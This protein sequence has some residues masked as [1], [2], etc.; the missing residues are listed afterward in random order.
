[1]DARWENLASNGIISK[2]VSALEKRKVETF[3]VEN[4]MQALEKALEIVPKRST[5]YLN[6]SVTLDSIGLSKII[7]ASA[8]YVS[9]RKRI[10]QIQDEKDRLAARKAGMAAAD[11]T[12]GSAQAVTMEGQIVFGSRSGSQVAANSFMAAHVLLVIGTQKIVPTLDEAILRIRQYCIDKEDERLNRK[13]ALDSLTKILII[14]GDIFPKRM[15]VILVKEKL[16][17]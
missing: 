17:Y 1:M 16:G 8:D 11:I 14:E 9:V 7:D 15:N 5:V 4:G 12:I 13:P 10:T 3:V 2:T 6:S